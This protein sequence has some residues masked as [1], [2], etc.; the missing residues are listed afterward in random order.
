MLHQKMVN[1]DNPVGRI[2]SSVM[3]P[4]KVMVILT[5]SRNN[6]TDEEN[7]KLDKGLRNSMP[8]GNGDFLSDPFARYKEKDI[9]IWRLCY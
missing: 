5:S 3:D 6:N 1:E 2:I 7:K 8:S 9:K 4:D